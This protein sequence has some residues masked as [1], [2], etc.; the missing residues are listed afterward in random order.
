MNNLYNF[1]SQTKT[2]ANYFVAE[3]K[4]LYHTQRTVLARNRMI[5]SARKLHATIASHPEFPESLKLALQTA[6]DK[7]NIAEIQSISVQVQ[8]ALNNLSKNRKFRFK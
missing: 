7:G 3:Q 2:I 5:N 4:V 8:E 1:F 6:A